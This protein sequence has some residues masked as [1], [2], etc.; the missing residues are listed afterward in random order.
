MDSRIASTMAD[1]SD[2]VT[3]VV[4]ISPV[5]D[6]GGVVRSLVGISPVANTKRDPGGVRSLEGISPAQA[7]PESTHARITAN[8]NRLIPSVSPLSLRMPIYWHKISI[9]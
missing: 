8:A 5:L 2:L 6:T 7:V 9:V 3:P 1:D 4:G